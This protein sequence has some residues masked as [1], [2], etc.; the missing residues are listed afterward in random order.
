MVSDTFSPI[1]Y[2][3]GRTVSFGYNGAARPT[4]AVDGG[5]NYAQ[6]AAYAPPGLLAAVQNG[7]NLNSALFYNNRL[8][9]ASSADL[10]S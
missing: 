9:R 8:Q 5:N 4:S 2:P 6:N 10:R 7:T 3:N 1:G